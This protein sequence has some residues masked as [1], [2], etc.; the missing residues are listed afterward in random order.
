MMRPHKDF[1]TTITF[2]NGREFS[3]HEILALELGCNCYFAKPYPLW[4]RG[5]N[6]HTNGLIRQYLPNPDKPEPYRPVT[7]KS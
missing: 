7:S 1:V 5:L 4:E 6:E 3:G 2:D